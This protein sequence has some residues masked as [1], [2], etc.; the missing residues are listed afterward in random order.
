MNWYIDPTGKLAWPGEIHNQVMYYVSAQYGLYT[1]Q[2][3][4]YSFGW[5][6]ADLIGPSGAVWDVKRDKPRQIAT[7][8]AQVQKYVANTWRNAP[9]I[10]L[11]VGG[12][13]DPGS[14]VYQSGLTTYYVTYRYVGQGIIAYDYHSVTDRQKVGEAALGIVIVAGAA[15]LIYQTGGAAAPVLVPLLI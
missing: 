11:S 15:Y 12:L 2:R 7:G 14:F 13:I 5:G 4:D 6:R 1:E 3:I 10:P 8:V 9:N